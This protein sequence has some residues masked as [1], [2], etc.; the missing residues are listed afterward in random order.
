MSL[1]EKF[2]NIWPAKESLEQKNKR[3]QEV[4]NIVE[5]SMQ[6]IKSGSKSLLEKLKTLLK[7]ASAETMEKARKIAK[8][9]L[10][11]GIALVSMQAS[12]G[13]ELKYSKNEDGSINVYEKTIKQKERGKHTTVTKIITK[14]IGVAVEDK[15][16]QNLEINDKSSE[17]EKIEND[18]KGPEN[19]QEAKQQGIRSPEDLIDKSNQG[20]A[21][22][23]TPKGKIHFRNQ[24]D[25][26]MFAAIKHIPINTTDNP[27]ALV[28][29]AGKVIY[30]D[31]HFMNQEDFFKYVIAK[32]INLAP[33]AILDLANK[34][35]TEQSQR[36][37]VTP[38]SQS[39]NQSDA[40]VGG[41]KAKNPNR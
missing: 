25:L 32:K 9:A 26:L 1:Q 7:N 36:T 41:K 29:K 33:A 27:D 21:T 30:Q 3:E 5:T 31:L 4:K 18:K 23:T 10:A 40:I 19:N 22:I 20:P 2:P 28:N 34:L 13:Q 6:A 15:K 12:Q 16:N 38:Q 14:D 35:R 11:M 8:P 37:N 24:L 17:Q 39:Q